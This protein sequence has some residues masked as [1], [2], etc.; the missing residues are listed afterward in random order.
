[1]PGRV[2]SE[3]TSSIKVCQIKCGD[4]A[5]VTTLCEYAESRLVVN[6]QKCPEKAHEYTIP[7]E[8]FKQQHNTGVFALCCYLSSGS[9]KRH[10]HA[11]RCM[12]VPLT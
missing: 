10:S 4:P 9:F 6:F 7:V 12:F 1:M 11:G 5:T 2:A 8:I 3:R